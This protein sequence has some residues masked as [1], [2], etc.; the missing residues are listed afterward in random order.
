M[1]R[2]IPI[3][4]LLVVSSAIGG[5]D[6]ITIKAVEARL[7]YHHTGTLSEPITGNESLWNTVIGEGAAKEPSTALLVDVVVSGPAGDYR[8]TWKVELE[9]HDET[10]NKIIDRRSAEVGVLS[11]SGLF[12]VPFWLENTGCQRLKIRA[13]VKGSSK[14]TET[15]VPFACGE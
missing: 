5:T 2:L 8:T 1:K 3:L 11:A 6:V 12:H 15:V 14:W 4:L 10:N 9:V 7:F 13:R